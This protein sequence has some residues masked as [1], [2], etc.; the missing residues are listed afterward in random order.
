MA[1]I[2]K[3]IIPGILLFLFG[4]GLIALLI[5]RTDTKDLTDTLLRFS[6]LKLVGVIALS[7]L[8]LTVA[9]WRAYVILRSEGANIKFFELMGV[10]IAGNSLNYL[11]PF[12]YLGGEGLKGYILNERFGLPWDKAAAFLVFDRILEIT[13]SLLVV[14]AG[15]IAFVLYTG[16]PGL[17]K[18]I[19][20]LTYIL[21]FVGFL[22]F[23]F[24]FRV[25]RDKRIIQPLMKM[26]RIQNTRA[27][28]FLIKSE[29][30]VMRYFIDNRH[31]FWKAWWISMLKQV[32]FILRQG[33][34]LYFLGYGIKATAALISLAALYLGFI[35]PVPASLGVQ[36][37]FQGAVFSTFGIGTT[38][39]GVGF[40]LILR[41]ADIFIALTGLAIILRYGLSLLTSASRYMVKLNNNEGKN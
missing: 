22:I 31:V 23:L 1:V 13:T 33:A 29:D 8:T 32:A 21:G 38:G 40:S 20:T 12:V 17:T 41:A 37:A 14:I 4:I 2:K 16:L 5:Y 24:Y 36:E 6:P 27:G 3:K 25:M 30:D 11:T 9:N 34:L 28:R 15:I 35:I 7:F 39:Q 19:I 18:T 26:L 10:W